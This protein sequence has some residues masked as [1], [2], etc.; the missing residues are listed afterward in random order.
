MKILRLSKTFMRPHPR[1]GEPTGFK[2]K[3]LLGEKIHTLRENRNGYYKDGDI[4]KICEWEG[5]PFRSKPVTIKEGVRIG[6]VPVGIMFEKGMSFAYTLNN[7]K[8][9]VFV[10]DLARNDGLSKD[11]FIRWFFP[12]GYGTWQGSIIHFTDF[13]YT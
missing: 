13:R 5:E 1:T 3:F 6:V 11:D 9:E 8:N 7:L 12:D 10:K 2:E 4:V